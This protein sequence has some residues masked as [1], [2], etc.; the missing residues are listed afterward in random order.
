MEQV[1]NFLKEARVFYLATADGDQPRVR[2]LGFVMDWDGKLTFCTSNEKNMYK[3]LTANS[4]V[5]IGTFNGKETLRICGTAAVITSP[6]TQKKALEVMPDLGKMYSVGDGK[7]EIFC[8]ENA[9][10]TFSDMIGN[11]RDV[12]L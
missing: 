8:L 5:E 11:S 6:E 7:F 3:Q 4:K 10:A 12:A 2:P 1:L 9:K